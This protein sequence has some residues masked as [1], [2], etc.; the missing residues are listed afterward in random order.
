MFAKLVLNSSDEKVYFIDW[1]D[2]TYADPFQ[3]LAFFSIMMD[4]D[5]SEE[6]HFIECYLGQPAT[7]NEKKRFRIAKTT[8]FARL[9]LSGQGIG[10]RLGSDQKVEYS[11][12]EP[13]RE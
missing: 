7:T 1:G 8:N 9:V 12:E 10:D 2:G 4:Y 5:Q 11:L 6:A 3:D 13:K